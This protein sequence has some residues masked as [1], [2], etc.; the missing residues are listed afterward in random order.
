MGASTSAH[1]SDHHAIQLTDG[2]KAVLIAEGA[3]LHKDEFGT[4]ST[5][6][7]QTGLFLWSSAFVLARVVAA[8]ARDDVVGR[9]V[10]ELGAGCGLPGL[11]A[12]VAAS[13]A[14]VL[15]TDLNPATLD[16]LRHNASL[17]QLSVPHC[18]INVARLDWADRRTWPPLASV[19]VLGSDDA[20]F[21]Y[22]HTNGMD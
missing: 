20:L 10:C 4:H 14:N 15:L 13:A 9:S 3:N 21:H 16:M 5:E 6:S 2:D 12:A 19:Q 22:M 7:D 11:T 1:A 8:H 18:A 17:N